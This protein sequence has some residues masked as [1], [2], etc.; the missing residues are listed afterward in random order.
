MSPLELLDELK[1]LRAA[2][3]AEADPIL[4]DWRPWLA[5]GA[6]ADSARNLAHYLALRHRDLR[7]LQD[8]L[9]IL[10]LSSL[11]RLEGRVL[12]NLDAVLASLAAIAG[13][14]PLP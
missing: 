9:M 6:F 4:A 3:A 11:S 14:A 10:G 13:A 12:P 1:G 2:V 5:R 8:G 7:P